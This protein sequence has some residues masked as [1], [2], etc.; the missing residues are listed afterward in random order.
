MK[1][2]IVLFMICTSL[3]VTGCS[4]GDV[5]NQISSNSSATEAPATQAVPT[6]T[7]GP[8]E[9]VLAMKETGTVK[10]WEV[11]VKNVSVKDKIVDGKRRYFKPG[12]G[13]TYV[14]F[15]L[16]AK[17][18]GSQQENFLPSVGLKNKMMRA[19]LVDA[20]EKE[21]KPTQ[22][23]AYN[24]DLLSKSIEPS[25]KKS[26]IVVFEVPKKIGKNTDDLELHI[27]TAQEKLLYSVGK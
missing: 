26:G 13:K 22:L 15:S 14:V 18:K 6:A 25:K 5:V 2:G 12:K 21:Y 23:M 16:S 10:N 7:P 4:A 11:C 20:N 19:I 9:T 3:I 17:N 24:K 8:K 27:G 1:R